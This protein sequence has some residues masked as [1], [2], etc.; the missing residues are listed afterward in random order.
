[1]CELS[2]VVDLWKGAHAC[3]RV[4]FLDFRR[5]CADKTPDGDENP[6]N[7]M[8]AK[9]WEQFVQVAQWWSDPLGL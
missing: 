5:E 4:I 9:F 6:C 1:M 3:K 7:L 2:L 8:H